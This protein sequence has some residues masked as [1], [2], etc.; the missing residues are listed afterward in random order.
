MPLQSKV[1]VNKDITSMGSAPAAE[2]ATGT[3]ASLDLAR[4]IE[5][6]QQLMQQ[7]RMPGCRSS[8]LRAQVMELCYAF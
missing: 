1:R 4:V 8:V 5:M 7:V 2:E 3:A 6:Q